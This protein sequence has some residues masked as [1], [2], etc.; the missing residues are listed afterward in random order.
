MFLGVSIS[1]EGWTK[2]GQTAFSHQTAHQAA[3]SQLI[4][5]GVPN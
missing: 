2:T 5:H 4:I 1:Q 3:F